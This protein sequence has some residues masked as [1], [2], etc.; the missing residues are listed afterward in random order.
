EIFKQ[1]INRFNGT[2]L[3]YPLAL[4][5]GQTAVALHRMNSTGSDPAAVI[6]GSSHALLADAFRNEAQADIGAIRGFRYGTVVRP[7]L[8]RLEDLYYFI[9]IGPMIAKG[10]IKGK[11]LKNQIENSIDGSLNPNVSKWTGGGVVYYTRVRGEMRPFA[12][13]GER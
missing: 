13:H 6:E 1:H 9:P 8:V 7:G 2:R 12:K 4:M 5:V 10:T 11:Q 3:S